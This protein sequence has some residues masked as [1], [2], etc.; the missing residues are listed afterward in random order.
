MFF[1]QFTILC[2]LSFSHLRLMP[3]TFHQA[4]VKL[5]LPYK[6]ELKQFIT[7]QIEKAGYKAKNISYV[8]C[9]DEYL[10]DINRRF[11][12]H[13]YYTD[14]ITFPLSEDLKNIESEIYISLFRVMDNSE[15]IKDQNSKFKVASGK[16]K[17]Q[18]SRNPNSF[19][20]SSLSFELELQRV[21]FHGVLHLLGYKDKTR[22]EQAEM[23]KQEDLWLKKFKNFLKDQNSKT[24]D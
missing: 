16:D 9:S 7:T 22:A 15:K 12:N 6:K 8:F 14:I 5:K 20:L 21:V 23:R 18:K 19:D 11:L 13:D 2:F 1:Y 24:K 3:I 10:L 17:M 4:D